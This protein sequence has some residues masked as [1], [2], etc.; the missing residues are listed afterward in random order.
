MLPSMR[1]ISLLLAALAAFVTT[2]VAQLGG[3]TVI[4][5]EA[6]TAR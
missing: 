4:L 3:N 6:T 1:A 5:T 2:E